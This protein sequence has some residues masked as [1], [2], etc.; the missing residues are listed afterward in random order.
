M[1]ITLDAEPK[2]IAALVFALQKQLSGYEVNREKLRESVI[3]QQ[4]S[5]REHGKPTSP[6]TP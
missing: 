3:H 6:H 1:K 5:Q 4:E 2:E